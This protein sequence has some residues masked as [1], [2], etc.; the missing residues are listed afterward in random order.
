MLTKP[1]AAPA[2]PLP[3]S[4]DLEAHAHLR[5]A[6]LDLHHGIPAGEAGVLE[7]AAPLIARLRQSARLLSNYLCPADQRLQSFLFEY[8]ED[9]NVPRLPRFTL[10]L[11]RP[12][13]ARC[14]S[15]PRSRDEHES[16]MLKSYRVRQGV[17]HNPAADRRTTK[18]VFHVAEGGLAIPDDKLA[19][20][21]A[22]FARLLGAALEPPRDL[23]LLPYT[24]DWA[25]PA[26]CWV[27][28][29][30]RPLVCPAVPGF[31]DEQRM[32]VRFLAPGSLVSNLDFV[33][34]IFGN[35]GDPHLPENDAA[36][37]VAQWTGHTGGV[38][39]APHLTR[40]TK[41]EVGLPSWE[42]ATPRQ[43]RDGMCWRT[44]DE[45][46][47][48]GE[49][50][51]LTARDAS[52]VI[53]TVIADNYYGYC[54]KE[55]KT[56]IGFA[57]NL[58]GLCEEEHAGG[59]LVYPSYDLGEA[60]SG[61][62]HVKGRGHTF[63]EAVRLQGALLEVHADG[64]A[65]VRED[66]TI[67]LVPEGATFDLR[68]QQVEWARDG[69]TRRLK[70]LPRCTYVRPSGYRVTMTKPP[71]N[72]A[73]RLVGTVPEPT[74]CHKP[75]T[76]SG[77]GKSEISKP[78]DDAILHG[79]VFVADFRADFDQV[80]ALLNRDYA[81][82]FLDPARCGQD[83]R[84]ILSP[85]RSLGSVI[86]LL[87][88][89]ET[90]YRPEFN[91]WLNS[92]PQHIRELVFVVKRFYQPSWGECWR[93]RFSVDIRDGRP[94]NELKLD[95]RTL[96][97]N[98]L[99]VGFAADGSWRVFGLRKDFHSSAKIQ[100]EDDIT[101]SVVVPA[102]R[103]SGLNPNDP[104]PAVKFVANA[105]RRLFQ[106]PDDAIHRGYDRQAEADLAGAGNFLSN[107][108]PLT[109]PAVQELVDD[110]IGFQQFT[111]PMQALLRAAA[112]GGAPAYVV[113]SAHPRLVE[114]KPSKNPRYL[115]YR[116]DLQ[117][118]REAWLA[119]FC[120]R[121]ARRLASDQPL[122]TPVN[123]VVPGRRNNPPEPGVRP[124][125]VHNPI[126]YLELPEAFME[127]ISSMTG[128]SPSTTGAGS[129]GALT[130]GPF[131]ALL[132]IL[133]L[134]HFLLSLVLTGDPV[135]LSAAGY[136][137]PKVR[138]AHDVSLLIPELWCRLSPAERDPANLIRRGHFERC[139]DWDFEGRRVLASRLGYRV[140]AVFVREYFGRIF[141]CPHEVFT[142][143]MLQPERQDPAVFAEGIETIIETHRRTAASYFQD[144][145]LELACPPLRALLHIMRDGHYEGLGVEAPGV[146]QLFTRE[147]LLGSDWYARRLE[148]RQERE[149]R[150]WRQHV[151]SL[152]GFLSKET[153]AE[154][155][156]R[157]GIQERLDL[158]RCRQAEVSS[159]ARLEVLAGTLGSS[160]L[161]LTA[162]DRSAAS[163]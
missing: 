31:T 140:T 63:E 125:A 12:G 8:L 119:G 21:R 29:L 111:E 46:Y 162:T 113:S 118:P 145:S 151:R 124:L 59:A 78:L 105:E 150:L 94:G 20:P 137:G 154:E 60:Y 106:R 68:R 56:Q 42:E 82:R 39:L 129:E 17:L 142:E 91:R 43:R 65:T 93:E 13:L 131:N 152:E 130:K 156:V 114:G 97:S 6:L 146:R 104:H 76:V 75:C 123:A 122:H 102:D 143:E 108:E 61:E 7:V 95:G 134:N 36:L 148:A 52:G 72:R 9:Q 127:F 74:L 5:L 50:F 138:V 80:E 24:A 136:V 86:K 90:D 121:L 107:F 26:H 77:G 73:W 33:E 16:P 67:V 116:P 139:R 103:L 64:Y 30:L 53:L 157:L 147:S 101:A 51:K 45:R 98:Y 22:V 54:K 110:T 84:T 18:G 128:K 158:A 34:S 71:G 132:P 58:S 23:L 40:L 62:F 38:I 19:V 2:G 37:D 27:S 161:T 83:R 133:D 70:L 109:Q 69:Q 115:Q 15:L 4:T 49:A 96:V 55:V 135:F 79:P 126:H 149:I 81:D 28:L 120:T 112:A 57:A 87:T 163:S 141:N 10:I 47:N 144:G 48:E 155:A 32:E 44:P 92:I 89:S 117:A 159:P 41:R 153:Q 88:P 160:V 3:P 14:L 35:G 1:S 99:R 85:A 66:P 100:V 11:D 25:A